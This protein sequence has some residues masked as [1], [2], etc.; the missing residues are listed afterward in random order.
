M[1]TKNLLLTSFNKLDEEGW[2]Y[3]IPPVHG[4]LDHARQLIE[5]NECKGFG[6]FTE[7]NLEFNN[8][9]LQLKRIAQRLKGNQ[10]YNL[11]DCM[12]RL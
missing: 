6:I 2:V 12:N 5:A 11:T 1:E 4:V 3:L 7:S 8:K 10:I 9:I